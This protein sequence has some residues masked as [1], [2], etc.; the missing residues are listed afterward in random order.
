MMTMKELFNALNM[1]V[2]YAVSLVISFCLI[3]VL[4]KRKGIKFDYYNEVKLALL[5]GGTMFKDVKVKAIMAICMGIV[6]GL[7][8]ADKA[9]AEKRKMAIKKAIDEIYIQCGLTL[10]EATVGAII[11]IAVANMP[12]NQR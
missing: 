1:N 5:I 9:P 4:M 8:N 2:V 12:E 3:L 6:Q 11:D 10:D 7:E